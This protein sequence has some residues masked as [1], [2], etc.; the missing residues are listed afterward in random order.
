M[1]QYSEG[2]YFK[3]SYRYMY[4]KPCQPKFSLYK[5]VYTWNAKDIDILTYCS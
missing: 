1:F 3:L 2:N 5:I 4:I